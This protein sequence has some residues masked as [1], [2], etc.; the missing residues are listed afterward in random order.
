MQDPNYRPAVSNQ[1]NFTVQHQ[2]GSSLTLQAGY[3]GQHT[4]HLAAIVN[5]GQRVLLSDGT[6]IPGPYLAGN[7][8]LKNAGTGQVRLNTTVGIQNYNALQLSAQQRFS[9]GLSFQANYTRAKCLTNN[10]GYYGRYGDAEGSQ[11]SA[12][13]AFQQNAYNINQ[14]YG[15]CD[16]DVAHVFN[17]Y[18][19]Y[20]LPLGAHRAYMKDANKF[21]NAV[22]GDWQVNT[23]FT[24]H[25]GFPISMLD[26]AG[27]PGTGSFQPRP[28]C[29][30]PSKATPFKNFSGGG[31]VWFDP[32]TMADPAPG[33]FGNCGVSTERG[34]GIR[35][36]DVGLSKN[37]P[38]TE[39]QRVE[40]RAEAVNSFNTPIFT[41]NGYS[42]D[43]HGGSNEGVVNTSKGARNLQFALKY[44]F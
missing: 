43:V 2:L 23:I 28:D 24:V 44:I 7:P 4:D 14:D 25:G 16:H 11:A 13:V 6:S 41:V 37:F 26:W 32:S 22:L 42:I 17:G 27:D 15:Y 19:S 34:P 1:W 30:A 3:V 9:R 8:A 10:Q 35:Q 29:V 33:K 18:L 21:V 31:Y 40:L 38:I 12:D 20:D 36:I 5:A 39:R